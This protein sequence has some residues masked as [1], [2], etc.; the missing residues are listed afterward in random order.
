MVYY[1]SQ[2]NRSDENIEMLSKMAIVVLM[3][4]EGP[5][6]LKCC[7]N[8]SVYTQGKCNP[9]HNATTLPGCGP[10]CDQHG[11]QNQVFERVKAAAIAG[12]RR[13]PHCMLFANTV[14]EYSAEHANTLFSSP[15]MLDTDDWPFMSTHALGNA[16]DVLDVHG[17]PHEE[18]CDPGIFPSFFIE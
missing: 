2:W 1:G 6:W 8:A 5:C 4:E 17:K 9:K 10:E 14:C 18:S 11:Y 3:Q 7:P 12:G 13:P 15:L 16:V